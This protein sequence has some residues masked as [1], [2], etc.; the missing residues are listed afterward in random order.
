LETFQQELNSPTDSN[1]DEAIQAQ[2]EAIES[3]IK[4]SS[5]LISDV[6][7]LSTLDEDFAGHSVYLEKLNL[8]KEKYRGIRRLRRDG[9]CFYRAFGFAY[10]EYLLAGKRVK[11]A[12]R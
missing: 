10:I 2:Q 8:L 11:E 5:P 7:P 6:L 9:N 4:A 12:A 3:A 1:S